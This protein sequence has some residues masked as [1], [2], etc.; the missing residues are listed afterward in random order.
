MAVQL[1]VAI[2]SFQARFDFSLI[3][4]GLYLMLVGWLMIRSAYVP[5]WLGVVMV[6][7]GLGWSLLETGPYV[8]PGVDLGLLFVATFGEL[9]LL[10]WLIGWGLRLKH[11]L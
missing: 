8:L 3:V 1:Q 7:N 9:A 5:T 4:F 2:L 10:A 6:V 11:D